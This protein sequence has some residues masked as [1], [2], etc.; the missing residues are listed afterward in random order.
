MNDNLQQ[1][2]AQLNPANYKLDEPLKHH[3][4]V[5]IGGP[6]DLWYEAPT[7]DDFIQTIQSART[8][9]VPVTVLGRGANTLISDK[10]I[11]G[12]VIKN[13]S[14]EIKIGDET[15]VQ[16]TDELKSE[17]QSRWDSA[18]ET[19]G[20]RAM[21]D[22]KDLDYDE[23]S[24]PRIE[25]K[26]ESGVDMPFAMNYLIGQGIT[27]LQWYA[28]V[29]GTLGGW[30]F[31]NTH[32]GTHFIHEVIKDVTILDEENEVRTLAKQDLDLDYD[33]SR[34]HKTKE[35]ILGAT[36]DLYKGDKAK[37]RYVATEWAKRK[38]VQP[39]ISIGCIFKN[40][41]NEEKERLGYPS[42]SVGYLVEH[43]LGMKDFSIGD[44]VISPHHH[45]FI[46]NKGNATAQDFLAVVEEMKKRAR[47]QVGLELEPEIFM[48]GE[49]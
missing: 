42:T 26:L 25:V 8:L 5:R 4:T 7:T 21:Y 31:N 46:E 48:L 2:I 22:F 30:V 27:G 33:V 18:D 40:I 49:F 12:L 45:N 32:G 16:E 10:G 3:T 37:A 6:A 1:L 35:I 28:K 24:S 36:L 44:A 47:E 38:A 34:F 14:K 19:Q 39:A 41:S 23:S 43:V 9:T 11:R 15:P 29:P 13:G 17:V 20:A